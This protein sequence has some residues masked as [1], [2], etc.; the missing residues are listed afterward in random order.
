MNF[1]EFFPQDFNRIIRGPDGG[2]ASM[3]LFKFVPHD[4][5]I[6]GVQVHEHA[7][8]VMSAKLKM[9]LLRVAR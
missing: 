6:C 2:N 8:T 4:G 5:A 7:S 9:L 1:T 3:I